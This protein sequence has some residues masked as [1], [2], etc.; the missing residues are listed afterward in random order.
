MSILPEALSSAVSCGRSDKPTFSSSAS[1]G[2]EWRA[3]EAVAA[4]RW[5]SCGA[6]TARFGLA[7]V[8]GR[9]S[10]SCPH[11]KR[12]RRQGG[13]RAGIQQMLELRRRR[14]LGGLIAGAATAA[15]A[16]AWRAQGAAGDRS[17]EG[18]G[19]G[20]GHALHE[21]RHQDGRRS[22]HVVQREARHR[23]GVF[24]WRL[25]DV[26]S[27]VLAEADAGRLQADVVDASDI[28]ALLLMKERGILEPFRRVEPG[29]LG[30]AA[31]PSTSGTPTA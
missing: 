6:A 1:V 22:H 29:G 23:G 9:L 5:R 15:F 13:A 7:R 17:G 10:R 8:P 11:D 4:R 19:R 31:R 16:P 2:V 12:R 26:T 3:D 30:G 25:R 14:L 27:K 21:P 24:P 20:E 18:Q 28:A